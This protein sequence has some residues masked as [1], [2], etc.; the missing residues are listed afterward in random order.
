MT[1][2]ARRGFMRLGALLPAAVPLVVA[3]PPVV[4]AE[5][6]GAD[7]QALRIL[8]EINGIP[9]GPNENERLRGHPGARFELTASSHTPA[10]H[11]QHSP[12]SSSSSSQQQ[13]QQRI[14]DG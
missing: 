3:S 13:Q 12:K 9:R 14:S 4:A 11:R 5:D 1:G 7:Q 8:S 6:D 2:L 10:R